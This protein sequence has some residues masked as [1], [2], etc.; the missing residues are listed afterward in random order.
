MSR[1]LIRR[2][3]DSSVVTVRPRCEIVS[4][5]GSDRLEEV[6]WRDNQT[7]A[8]ESRPIHH[9]FLMMGAN[10]NTPWLSGCVAL[11]SG[12]FIKTGPELTADDLAHAKWPRAR[13]PYLLETSVPGVFAVGDVRAG[14]IKR[15]ASAVGEGSMSVHF[16]HKVLAE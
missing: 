9:V 11:D 4:L 13:P 15:V 6:T 14:N 5:A 12:G 3:E 7:G 2:I 8:L 10:P 16:I 1:Y